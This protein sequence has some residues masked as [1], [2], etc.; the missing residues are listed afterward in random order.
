MLFFEI[1]DLNEDVF[2]VNKHQI[3]YIADQED[4]GCS[5]MLSNGFVIKTNL[6]YEDLKD[7]ADGA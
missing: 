1:K 5:L 7:L 2:Y 3:L 4:F 6:K